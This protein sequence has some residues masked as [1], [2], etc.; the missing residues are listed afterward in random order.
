M[1]K[2]ILAVVTSSLF[3]ASANAAVVYDKDGQ[4]VDVY[5]RIQYQAGQIY[6]DDNGDAENF[7]GDTLARFGFNGKW[8]TGY[9]DIA[10]I[11]KLEREVSAEND[12][13]EADSFVNRYAF[14]GADFGNGVQATVGT[15]DSAYVQL[16]DVTDIY[17]EYSGL[18]ENQ[19][20][21]RWDDSAKVT[22]AADGWDLRGSV[23]FSDEAKANNNEE[24]K[25][26][27]QYAASA[28]YTFQID[29]VSSLKPVLAYQA[30]T[31]EAAGESYTDEQYAAGLGYTY[32]AFYLASTYGQL[33][34]DLADEKDTVW[35]VTATYKVQPDWTLVA[36]YGLIDGHNYAPETTKYYVLGTQYD[37]TAKAKAYAEYKIN[38]VAGE[39]DNYVVGLQYNF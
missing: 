8:A 6:N 34:H 23:S 38:E 36:G 37:I 14:A 16:A 30:K 20:D 33:K 11:S 32:D 12:D 24:D 22:Y 9:N 26:Q 25:L 7:G 19:F 4:Q 39:D 21:S 3:A 13:D 15:Q 28:G 2:T 5:G 29:E 18:I 10:L 17:N 31:G 35:T 1:K 27:N